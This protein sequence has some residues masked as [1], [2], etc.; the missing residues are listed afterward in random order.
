MAN[1]ADLVLLRNNPAVAEE[2]LQAAIKGDVDAQYGMGLIYAEGRGVK[3]DAAKSFYWL[4]RAIGQGDKDAALLRQHV[5]AS[6]TPAQFA[7][8]ELLIYECSVAPGPVLQRRRNQRKKQQTRT[9][10]T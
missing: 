4:T 2:F 7:R 3:Q 1:L 6:M 5:A 8:A 10:E 9:D